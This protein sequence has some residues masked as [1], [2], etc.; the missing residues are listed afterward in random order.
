MRL[1]NSLKALLALVIFLISVFALQAFHVGKLREID[2]ERAYYLYESS[3]NALQV[4]SLSLF[5]L[6][7]VRGE[8][9][10]FA[11]ENVE[12]ERGRVLQEILDT[13]QAVILE[14]EQAGDSE[15]YYAYSKA[16]GK[17]V[18]IANKQV[19]LHIV[20]AGNQVAVGTPIIFGG[21]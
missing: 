7:Q 19:N 18:I 11:L 8:S 1:K 4:Q 21:F 10:R 13:Y 2:G 20:F 17:G 5:E 15:S 6:W 16:L 14:Y 3:S 9:V 12:E